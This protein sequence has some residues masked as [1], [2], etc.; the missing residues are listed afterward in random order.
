MRSIIVFSVLTIA[1]LSL[2]YIGEIGLT[3]G[4]FLMVLTPILW[5]ILMVKAVQGTMY[6]L[7]W[8]DNLAAKW[9]GWTTS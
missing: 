3:I 7:P 8:A 2:N 1:F 6:K 4:V 5:I 9:A